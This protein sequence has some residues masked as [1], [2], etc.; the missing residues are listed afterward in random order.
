LKSQYNK[1]RGWGK[2]LF[3]KDYGLTIQ[4]FIKLL[5]YDRWQLG[6]RHSS[7]VYRLTGR[8]QVPLGP[9]SNLFLIAA[10]TWAAAQ[11]DHHVYIFRQ[12]HQLKIP[13][14]LSHLSQMTRY[15]AQVHAG[16][17][18]TA[19]LQGYLNFATVL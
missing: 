2:G 16:I 7:P 14:L 13:P 4:D 17:A 10:G 11:N 9:G 19:I 3:A 12:R 1:R 5:L 6:F 15:P 18:G 8:K